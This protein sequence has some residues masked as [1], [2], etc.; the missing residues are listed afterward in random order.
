MLFTAHFVHFVVSDLI[1]IK[2]HETR[3]YAIVCDSDMKWQLEST[4]RV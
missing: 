2:L 3:Y 4:L 1:E